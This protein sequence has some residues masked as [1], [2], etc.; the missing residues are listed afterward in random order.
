MIPFGLVALIVELQSPQ[1]VVKKLF[2]HGTSEPL[3]RRG[4][5]REFIVLLVLQAAQ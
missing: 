1:V 3:Y 4:D 2:R 5:Y